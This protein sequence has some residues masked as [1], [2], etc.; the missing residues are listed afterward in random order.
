M[1][2]ETPLPSARD[3]DALRR[4]AFHAA[5]HVTFAFLVFT[6]RKS[7]ICQVEHNITFGRLVSQ[8]DH[9]LLR[10]GGPGPATTVEC[11][12]HTRIP[13]AG[14]GGHGGDRARRGGQQG[15]AHGT[16][17]RNAGI[18]GRRCFPACWGSPPSARREE[19]P[20]AGSQRRCSALVH[21][22]KTRG[23]ADIWTNTA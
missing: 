23:P 6:M 16:T 2:T 5:S 3:E 18:R 17:S 7:L 13:H 10:T 4:V 15:T 11:Q 12:T 22:G 8:R 1:H 19:R 20:D 21:T 9:G 14:H